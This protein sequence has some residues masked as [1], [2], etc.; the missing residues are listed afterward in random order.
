[1]NGQ[2]RH[3]G[4]ESV[5]VEW[6]VFRRRLY[7]FRCQR[8]ALPDHFEGRFHGRDVPIDWLVRT[9]A[10]TDVQNCLRLPKSR[11]NRG[12]DTRIGF[13]KLS[14]LIPIL[15]YLA[16]IQLALSKKRASASDCSFG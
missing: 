3:S 11:L 5:V 7:D 14:V 6:K 8:T 12:C 13:A 2:Y 4:V 10:G 1:M 16:F 9:G 15:S